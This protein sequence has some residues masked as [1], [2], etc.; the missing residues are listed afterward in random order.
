MGCPVRKVVNRCAGRG[1]AHERAADRATSCAR[2]V[3]GEHAAGD[4]QDPARLGRQLAQRGRGVAGARGRRARR[5]WRST[6]ARAPRSSR[7]SAHWDMIGEAKRAVGIPVIG[8]GDVRNAD[9]AVRMLEQTGCDG[10]DAGPRRVRRPVGVPRACARSHERGETLPPPTAAERLEAGRAPPGHD[11]ATASGRARAA[12]EMRKHVAWYIKGLPHSARVREQVNRTAHGRRDGRAAARLPRG[13]ASARPRALRAPSRPARAARGRC[14]RP[15]ELRALLRARAARRRSRPREAARRDRR[16]AR[17]SG[18]S[19]PRSTTS[20]RC[21]SGSPRWCSA[22]AR[23]PRSWWRSSGGCS[24]ARGLVLATRVERAGPR[25]AARARFPRAEVHERA[26]AVVLR[27]GARARGARPRARGVRRH[28]RPAGGRGGAGHRAR[29]WAAAPSW[30]PTS[31]SPGS[32]ACSRIAQR[33]RARAR[34]GGGG[35]ARGRAAERGRRARR[36]AG[37]R[38]AHQR[39][40]RCALRRAGAA[41]RHAQLVRGRAS[42]WSTW[43]TA[44]ARATPRTSS[45]RRARERP[46]SGDAACASPT[47]TASRGSAAT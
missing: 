12:R 36:P 47:S 27:R 25:G 1:A 18:S 44:S 23:R 33:L 45:T 10:G 38:G 13:A 24:R 17:S 31:A 29:A 2:M 28:R 6:P 21:A 14:V 26:R 5:R 3:D 22:R 16:G 32:T 15:A 35:R 8:N 30:S 20:A 37:D 40:L 4:R 39:R 7:A 43:T 41:A 11:G 34:A 19:S 42:P 46:E 9:D